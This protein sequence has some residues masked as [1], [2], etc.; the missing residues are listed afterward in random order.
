MRDAKTGKNDDERGIRMNLSQL[1]YFIA[2]A[3]LEHYGKAANALYITQPALSNSISRLEKELGVALFQNEGRNVVLTPIGRRFFESVSKAMSELDRGISEA[4]EQAKQKKTDIS[5]GSVAALMRGSLS[6]FLNRY[7][8]RADDP[9]LFRISQQGSTRESVLHIRDNTLDCAFCGRPVNEAGLSWV[10]LFEQRIVA[11]VDKDN[12]LAQRE[13]VT[14]DDLRASQLLSYRPPSYMY[15]ALEG[16]FKQEGLKV[17]PAFEDEISSLSVAAVNKGAVCITLDTTRDVIWDSLRMV[18]IQG[19]EEP[20]HHV[21][22]AWKDR[23]EESASFGPFI[24]YISNIS[25]SYGFKEPLENRY[26]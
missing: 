6:A 8:E 20:Y 5:V 10:P 7:N 15:Y 12:P 13:F 26:V 23:D 19:Y 9:L 4:Q 1:R 11:L 3:Q 24:E 16:L 25:A 22:F 18:P 21:G 2:V 14:L 17:R